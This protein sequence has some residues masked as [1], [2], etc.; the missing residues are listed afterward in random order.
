SA[1]KNLP[2]RAEPFAPI[3]NKSLVPYLDLLAHTLLLLEEMAP[4]ES[5]P[6]NSVCRLLKKISEATRALFGYSCSWCVFVKRARGRIT[7]TIAANIADLV[8][9]AFALNFVEGLLKSFD[10]VQRSI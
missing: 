10:T 4:A 2:N 6:T 3:E 5:L 9:K 1:R 7:S 8:L